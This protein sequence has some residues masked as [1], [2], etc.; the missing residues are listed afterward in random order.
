MTSYFVE[1]ALTA[2]HC[3]CQILQEQRFPSMHLMQNTNLA[4]IFVNY[5]VSLLFLFHSNLIFSHQSRIL[6]CMYYFHYKT[7]E[8]L[9]CWK[10]WFLCSLSDTRRRVYCFFKHFYK[11]GKK[12]KTSN[13]GCLW[14]WAGI[15][16]AWC[17]QALSKV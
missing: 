17:I 9:L 7:Y 14:T 12:C 1:I 5:S 2:N 13:I 10:C 4:S 3:G 8:L 16:F 15:D 6:S 11:V